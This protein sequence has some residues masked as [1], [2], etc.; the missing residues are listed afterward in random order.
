M[1]G[2]LKLMKKQHSKKILSAIFL[3]ILLLNTSILTV[4]IADENKIV[5]QCNTAFSKGIPW[6]PMNTI[7]KTTLVNFDK[8]SLTDDYA[9]LASIPA[10]VFSDGEKL[11]T[12]PLLFFQAEDGYPDEEKY[13]F[14]NDYSGIHYFMEDF[15]GYCDGEL[16][17]LTTINVENS[18]IEWNWKSKKHTK[19]TGDDPFTLAKQIALDE[20]SYSNQAILAVIN[21]EYE[22]PTETT[23]A[24][25]YGEIKGSIDTDHFTIGRPYGPASEYESFYINEDYKYVEV[26]LWYP[27]IIPQ[28]PILERFTGKASFVDFLP[29]P[30]VNDITI[31][32]VDPDLQL[33]CKY[34]GEWLQ[35]SASS[36]MAI[37]NGPHEEVFSYVYE[38]GK[39][40]VGVTN[41]PT[42]GTTEDFISEGPFGRYIYYG[43]KLDAIKNTLGLND[44]TTFNIDVT[45]YPGVEID[46]PDK[47][48]FGSKNATFTLHWKDEN[49]NLG[50]TLLGPSGEEIINVMNEDTDTQ[51][52]EMDMIGECLEDEH[53]QAVVYALN[54]ISEPVPFS[55][56]YSWKQK[57]SREKGDLIASSCQAAVLAS[58]TNSPL[59]FIQPNKLPEQTK[60][61]LL[62]LGVDTVDIIN[63]GNHLSEETLSEIS[64]FA[65][66][67]NNYKEYTTIYQT[68]TEKTNCNDIVFSTLD[69]W[70][71]W[72]YTDKAR[73]LKPD[74]EYSGAHHFAPAAYAA[75]QHGT[76][77]LLVE[78]HPALSGAVTWHRDF[79]QKNANGHKKPSTGCMFLT[80]TRV[81][82]FLEDQGFDKKGP[83]SILTVAGQ[84]EIGPT[85]TRMFTGPDVANPGSIIGTP[86]DVTVH[87]NRCVFYPGLIFENPALTEKIELENGSKS[88]RSFQIDG[89]ILNPFETIRTRLSPQSPGL[90][91]LRITRPSGK[92]EYEYPVL[93]TYGC[94]CHRFNE[95]SSKYWGSRYQ[96]RRG[97]TPGIDISSEEIDQG[98]RE[99]YEGKK[100]AFLP[101]LS[102]SD[103]TP[104]YSSKAGYSNA[105][106]T[107]FEVTI[108]NLNQGV[109][110]WYMVLHGESGDGGILSWW[111]K[112]TTGLEK[113]YGIT[114]RKA[115]F[116][117]RII[118]LISGSLPYEETNPWRCYDMWW[119]STE[120][121]DS[122]VMNSKIGVIQGWTNAWRP[123]NLLGR[124]IMKTGLDIVPSH[125]S[126]YYDGMVGPYGITPFVTKFLYSHPATE[127]DDKLENLHSMDFYA[128]SC[129]IGYNYLQIAMMRHGSVLQE[130]DPWP[131]SYWS[132]YSLQQVPKEKALG[133][134]V[135]ESYSH[136]ITEIGPQYVFQQ[137]NRDWWWD[138]SE[139][140]V[141]SADPDLRIWVPNTEYDDQERNHWERDD[142]QP[143]AFDT[144]LNID[145]HQPFG[146]KN[147]PNE[148]GPMSLLNQYL[149]PIIALIAI[150][151]LILIALYL[152]DKTE[153]K[154]D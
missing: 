140:V 98:V 42:E 120:E 99:L 68:I 72:Y 146:P 57:I 67:G 20:W 83:E 123:I 108:N 118:G 5:N 39:W 129:L 18:N 19:I 154:N 96:T 49:V 2:G 116:Y 53:Y 55:I 64:S 138:T 136:G 79:W 130:M 46:I 100:G 152:P 111:E 38:P 15:M 44:V 14:L 86:V 29:V 56:D 122:A 134:T 59:L 93:H 151:I 75:A 90:T 135:G 45:K 127:V 1:A 78:N 125:L 145:G 27:A 144:G 54:D 35:T 139:N 113:N 88:T 107:N 12:N 105:F 153:N 124:G 7:K 112:P 80:G 137:E 142:V 73:Q 66:I 121:P 102:S 58:I 109:I 24:T 97:Y 84:Y 143:I 141:L 128:G 30:G 10:S 23:N 40:R 3:I 43:N 51:K 94:Y 63:L 34:D 106:S 17:K 16:D 110:T 87:I 91:N 147:H 119:G 65:H 77:V 89:K 126:G 47:P 32:S 52:I 103:Y 76:P 69:A 82:D 8:D 4:T 117:E 25:I 48:S 36:N 85:W 37:T 74:G 71:Y 95:R 28:R 101:D 62:T 6:Q 26:D 41:M 31:P 70:S 13:R 21:E 11:Y 115:A 150:I 50:L 148:K 81:Y 33:Y 92:E 149:V 133:Q 114:G 131:T 104:F 22:E 9:Y 60:E 61:T 132:S